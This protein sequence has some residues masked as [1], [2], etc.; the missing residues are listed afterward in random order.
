MPDEAVVADS[1]PLIALAIGGCLHLLRDLYGKVLVPDAVWHEVTEAGQGKAGAAEIAAAAWLERTR[2]GR[3]PD[4]LLRAELG[5]GEAEAITL[6]A[7]R[8][9]LLVVDER[10]ARRIA[11]MAYGLRVRGTV[12]TLVLAKRRGLAAA[13]RPILE[14]MRQGGY[15]LSDS[16]IEAA[17]ESMGEG[18]RG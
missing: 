12:G 3:S 10:Q 14:K 8:K 15:Y 1:G 18:G 6:A 9:G 17:C 5:P 11:E 4:P 16:L 2:L 7:E 13:V